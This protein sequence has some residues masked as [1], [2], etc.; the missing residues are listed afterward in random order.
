MIP[1]METI[2]KVFRAVGLSGIGLLGIMGCSEREVGTRERPFS[3]YF[4]PSVDAESIST[5][6][7]DLAQFVSRYVSQK[8][9]GQDTGFYTVSAMPTSYI[10]V[11]EAFGTKKA[12][13]AALT[14]FSYIL[15]R[16][17]KKYDVEAAWL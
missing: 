16:D 8:L 15:A 17:I 3:M 9:Y 11:V 5:N 6:A 13:F 12:D 14:T 7:D 10:A 1:R 4:I 2:K